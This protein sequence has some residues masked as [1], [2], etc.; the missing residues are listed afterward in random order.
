MSPDSKPRD[1]KVAIWWRRWSGAVALFLVVVGGASGF[2]K[3]ESEGNT[4]ES[5]FCNLTLGQ[6][7]ERLDRISATKEF[8][9][10]PDSELPQSLIDL[11]SYI[12]T[13]SLP[14][15][16]KEL[17]GEERDIPDLCWKYRQEERDERS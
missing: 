7:E 16:E 10:T 4:R 1:H 12:R 11:K 15:T 14:Q 8:L 13:V 17:E 2:A 3:I 6:Y 5:Q 9:D